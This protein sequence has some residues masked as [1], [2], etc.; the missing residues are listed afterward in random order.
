MSRFSV[1]AKIARGGSYRA[2]VSLAKQ[3][4]VTSGASPS[5]LLH[6]APSASKRH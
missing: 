3:G 2:Y 1:I 4:T 5:L 6:A